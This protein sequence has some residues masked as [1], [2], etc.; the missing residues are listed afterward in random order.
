[1]VQPWT[2]QPAPVIQ[3]EINSPEYELTSANHERS[4]LGKK[5]VPTQK[6]SIVSYYLFFQ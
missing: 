2:K 6:L 1:M 4:N 3:T 5:T